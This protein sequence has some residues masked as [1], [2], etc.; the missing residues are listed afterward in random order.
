MVNSENGMEQITGTT[1]WIAKYP[2]PIDRGQAGVD[3]DRVLLPWFRVPPA[4]AFPEEY[5]E[6]NDS[7][8]RHHDSCGRE[9][10]PAAARRAATLA[11]KTAL[12]NAADGRTAQ[13]AKR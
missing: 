7:L 10:M 5:A 4:A 11:Q 9:K 1:A 6:W 8:L 12:T 2:R 13:G 3:W